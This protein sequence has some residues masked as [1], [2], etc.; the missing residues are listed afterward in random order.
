MVDHM[1]FLRS[2]AWHH[3]VE[4]AHLGAFDAVLFDCDGTLV[5]SEPLCDIAWAGLAAEMRVHSPHELDAAG[6]SFEQRVAS[7]RPLN[8]S[9]PP[10]EILYAEYWA[11]L[12]VV[13]RAQLQPISATYRAAV[14]LR[15]AR[16]PIAVVSNSEQ[17]RLE[18]TIECAAPLLSDSLLVGWQADRRPKPAPDLY[19][20]AASLLRIPAERCLALEDTLVGAT[21]AREAGM[22]VGIVPRNAE[23]DP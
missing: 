18:F 14:S 11:R 2:P 22:T 1:A 19:V 15:E 21:A 5:D 20:L 7:L 12:K 4:Q 9:M 10:T 3:L 17:S 8:P 23:A 16:I 6:M 13:Y